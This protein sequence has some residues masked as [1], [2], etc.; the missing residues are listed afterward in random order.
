MLYFFYLFIFLTTDY[1]FIKNVDLSICNGDF[2][3]D[4]WLNT[5]GSDLLDNLRRTVRVNESRV[6]PHLETIPSLRTFTTKSFP[7]SYSQ[8]LGRH[9]N[10]SF[11]F[12]FFSF[13]PSDQVSIYYRGIKLDFS[14]F[15]TK[16][17]LTNCNRCWLR[18]AYKTITVIQR[19]NDL[20]STMTICF[21]YASV[22]FITRCLQVLLNQF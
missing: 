3:L 2:K 7:C 20:L 1:Q 9:L 5:D 21:K 12:G 18:I 11:H 16:A 10:R 13:V 4:S 17:G 19:S 22:L 14:S 8:S 6:D 15:T